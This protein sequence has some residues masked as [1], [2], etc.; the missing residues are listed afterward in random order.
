MSTLSI[1][2]V[3]GSSVIH[4]FQ[5]IIAWSLSG[6]LGKI[7]LHLIYKNYI[8]YSMLNTNL[9]VVMLSTHGEVLSSL[10][11]FLA[12]QGCKSD[13]AGIENTHVGSSIQS[14]GTIIQKPC[15]LCGFFVCA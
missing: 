12:Q 8:S 10:C 11:Q 1:R 4:R 13:H 5:T 7:I 2:A 15:T 14:P 3:P 9:R 6:L